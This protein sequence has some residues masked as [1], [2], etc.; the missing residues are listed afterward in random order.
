MAEKDPTTIRL[1]ASFEQ[2]LLGVLDTG[3][4]IFIVNLTGGFIPALKAGLYQSALTFVMVVVNTLIFQMLIRRKHQRAAVVLP[5]FLTTTMAY[6]LHLLAAS[7]QPF[8]SALTVMVMAIW[9]FVLLGYFQKRFGT[10]SV[11]GLSRIGL[12]KMGFGQNRQNGQE[13]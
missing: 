6:G 13:L 3:L 1:G 8:Y 10:I 4:P 7:P 2:G 9:Y 5:V 11:I 12:K